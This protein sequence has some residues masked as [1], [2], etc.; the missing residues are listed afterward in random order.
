MWARSEQFC[1]ALAAFGLVPRFQRSFH[2]RLAGSLMITL[3][4]IGGCS[5][6]DSDSNGTGG[7]N[8]ADASLACGIG[9]TRACLGP[10]ACAGAQACLPERSGFGVCDCATAGS[11]GG[12][13][14]STGSG[15]SGP[16]DG[17]P[18][19]QA[20]ETGLDPELIPG[21]SDGKLCGYSN[22]AEPHCESGK[23]CKISTA[24][25][26]TC[27]ETCAT[28]T[29][30]SETCSTNADCN[31]FGQCYAGRC[32]PFCDLSIA[33]HACSGN[34]TCHDVGHG[35]VGVCVEPEGG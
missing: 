17:S 31:L 11:G 7:N 12:G 33:K 9:D 14:G 3:A 23:A 4:A 27:D 13:S 32:A 21:P 18:D 22:L 1:K 19:G 6:N 2:A 30:C 5:G 29:S 8:G 16:L 15:G 20:G 24:T 25:T 10:A 28:P 26:M 34:E 35:H